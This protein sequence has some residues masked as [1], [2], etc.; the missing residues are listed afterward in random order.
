MLMAVLKYRAKE[1][2]FMLKYLLRGYGTD[3]WK[4]F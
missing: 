3:W 4:V 1:L 2:G